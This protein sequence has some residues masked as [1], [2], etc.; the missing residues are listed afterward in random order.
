MSNEHW[1]GPSDTEARI[2]RMND[3]T[4]P[5]AYKAEHAVDL[6]TEADVAATVTP[7]DRGAGATGA[8]TLFVA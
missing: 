7:A 6:A 8:E 4:A 5:V 1:E 3:G 2:A